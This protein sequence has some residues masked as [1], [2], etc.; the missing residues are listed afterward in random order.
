MGKEAVFLRV[1]DHEI[2]GEVEVGFLCIHFSLWLRKGCFE[3]IR[4]AFVVGAKDHRV[5]TFHF[6]AQFLVILANLRKFLTDH[7]H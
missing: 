1:V 7:W 5:T 2:A 6:E 4:H 3:A